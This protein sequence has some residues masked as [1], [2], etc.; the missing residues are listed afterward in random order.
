MTLKYSCVINEQGFYKTRVLVTSDTGDF[1][2]AVI[3]YHHLQPGEQL[4][5]AEIPCEPFCILKWDGEKW[6]EGAT[7]KQIA[8]WEAAKPKPE[9]APPS[10]SER[11]EALES[12][13][14]AVLMGGVS[15]VA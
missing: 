1:E 2:N 5:D 9:S 15:G 6:T 13:M 4:I 8:A 11:L 12:A 10:A 7:D 3:H 14:L